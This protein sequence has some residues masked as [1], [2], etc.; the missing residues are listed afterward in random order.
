MTKI[1]YQEETLIIIKLNK[2]VFLLL[3][4]ILLVCI[5]FF[6]VWYSH[7]DTIGLVYLSDKEVNYS[8]EK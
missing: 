8:E 5:G 2:K 7:L 3:L 4:I 1:D 6:W